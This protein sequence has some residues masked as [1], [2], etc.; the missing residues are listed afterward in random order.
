MTEKAHPHGTACSE[1]KRPR[2]PI[3]R[4][5]D[6]E[7]GEH[8]ESP[9]RPDRSRQLRHRHTAHCCLLQGITAT[10]QLSERGLHKDPRSF[11]L[12]TVNPDGGEGTYS[13]LTVT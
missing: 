12:L 8:P 2:Y 11:L 9:S 1:I 5:L 10:H 13:H 7:L 6:F 3:V 4:R